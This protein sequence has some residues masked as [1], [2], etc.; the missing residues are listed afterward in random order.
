[1]TKHSLSRLVG[2]CPV[3]LLF[4]LC[5]P[6]GAD[7]TD[8]PTISFRRDV[9]PLLSERC[10]ACHGPDEDAREADLRLDRRADATAPRDGTAAIV[11]GKP[12]QSEL[13]HRLAASDPD[14][15]MPPPD[16]G[17]KPLTPKQVTL[18][19]QWIEQGAP[20]SRHWAYEPP[21]RPPLP[22]TRFRDRV[23]TPIDA[24]VLARLEAEG[25]APAPRADRA[26]LIRRLYLDLIGL[27]PNVEEVDA[28]LSDTSSN[29]YARV[30]DRLLD[31]P[32]YGERWGR[33]WLDAARYADSDGFEKDKPREVWFYR[34]WAIR[35]LNRD[36]P[37]DRFIIEQIA[38]DLLPNA[39]QDQVVAT[40]FLRNS[41]LNEEGGID[42]EE[43]RM[44]AM[45]DRMD[46]I[47]KS[48]L[49]LTLQCGQCHH[50]K[51]EPFSQKDYY[52]LFAFLNNSHEAQ[53][54]VYTREQQSE[55]RRILNEIARIERELQN[56]T[57]NWQQ[58]M[59]E[60]ESTLER[61]TVPWTV[62]EISNAGDN[63][64]RY[65]RQEDGSLLAQGYAPT[66][67]DATFT[68]T[69]NE[70]EIRSFR[71]ELFTDPNL[72]AGGPG[73]AVDGQIAL[74]EFKVTATSV[75]DPSRK[76]VVKFVRAT[77]D[78]SNPPKQLKAPY[79]D[80]KGKSSGV[81]GPVEYAIDGKNDT[82][83]GIDAGPGR[84]NQARQAVFVAEEN[85]AFPG[86]TRLTF[87]LSQRQGGWNSDDNQNLNLGRFRIS[88]SPVEADADPI[89]RAIR[90]IL[91]IPPNERGDEQI[92][93]VFSYWR[94]TVKEWEE[95]NRRIEQLWSR[96]PEGTTQFTLQERTTPRQTFVLERGDF[97]KPLDPVT[98]GTPGFLHAFDT[99]GPPTRLDFARW[100]VARDSPTTARSIVNRIWQAYFGRGLVE[101]PED[102]GTTGSP[103]SHPRLL[104]WLAVE[105]MDH[106][107]RWKHIHRLIVMSSVY[108]QSSHVSPV[109]FQRDPDN[110]LLARGPRFRVDAE[111]VHDI[112]LAASGLLNR[113]VGGRSVYPPAPEFLFQ[114]PASYGPK[115]WAYDR[116]GEQYRR[117]IYTFR[118]RS[119][120]HPPL[121][122]FDA[123]SGE[124]S[125]VKRP[126]TNTPLQALVTLNEPLFFEC[127]QAL[128]RRSL[129]RHSKGD[130]E[131]LTYAFRCCVAR[132]PAEDELCVLLELLQTQRRRFKEKQLDPQAILVDAYGRPAE[133]AA[134]VDDGELAAW[135]LVCR[136]LLNL[137][138]TITKE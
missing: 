109:A 62:L 23:Q 52:R 118:F 65:Y 103:P 56:S 59:A 14:V 71:L 121:Q 57:P 67:F 130:R 101:T 12:D 114:R 73:R 127:A 27:P 74:S 93:K 135:T 92:A 64:Q 35:S 72:P 4:L 115:T 11:P 86:G 18:I 34:D 47:G 75:T 123:P 120:P 117:A 21:R 30:V 13:L 49:G 89:P 80:A 95:A 110:R 58:R 3:A 87:V 68:A 94:T 5:S 105:L 108:Q 76:K 125:T 60:W 28:F 104:D 98:P 79:T 15:V 19:R 32:H 84:R 102:L 69:T 6:A 61:R 133:R 128:A 122:A 42:P 129:A 81:I 63:N 31:S 43:F 107:W 91:R 8:L 70:S 78:Y 10:F 7:D 25:L 16:S 24:F 53:P 41:M 116:D 9:L 111:I 82:G 106:G 36:M 96:H 97:L 22:T 51:Y 124:Y 138:E 55:R 119:V 44:Q 88:V 85:A 45:F 33:I 2:F 113:K 112:L 99:D 39:T 20:W 29:A 134:G 1:M 40:G 54:V 26:T 83:W 131:R 66:R 48:V 100:L 126:R 90:S 37:Y 17:K 38:G 132:R 50:H 136:V 137:D 46:A 77:A